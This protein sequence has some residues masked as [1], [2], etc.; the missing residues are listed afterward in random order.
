M[1]LIKVG[2]LKW[3]AA[4]GVPYDKKF[5]SRLKG[6]FYCVSIRPALLYVTECWPVKKVV[7]QRMDVT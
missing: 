3:R 5:P 4:T 6:K 2:W 1:L 7:E